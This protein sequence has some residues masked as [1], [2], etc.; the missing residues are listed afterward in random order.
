MT[1]IILGVALMMT[2]ILG[3]VWLHADGLSR[4]VSRGHTAG[5]C[6]DYARADK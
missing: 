3:C 1:N 5:Q 4:C 2:V 6:L